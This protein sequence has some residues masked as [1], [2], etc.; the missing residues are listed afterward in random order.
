[1]AADHADFWVVIGTVAP[2]AIAADV[3]IIGQSIPL[4][5]HLPRRPDEDSFTSWLRQYHLW[6]IGADL[7]GCLAV[8]GIG[9]YALWNGDNALWSAWLASCLLF[10]VLVV[11][12]ILAVCTAIID[13]HKPLIDEEPQ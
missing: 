3:F 12:C 8:I 1:M 4:M 5:P 9:L 10:A 13:R 2:I 6:F 7:A 11:L